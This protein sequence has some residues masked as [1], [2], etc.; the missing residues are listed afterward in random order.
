M[1]LDEF[2]EE[3]AKTPRDW[4]NTYGYV[5]RM[6]SDTR[7]CPILAVG[8]AKGLELPRTPGG[9]PS[10]DSAPTLGP[11]LGLSPLEVRQIMATADGRVCMWRER[12][13]RNRLLR[14]CGLEEEL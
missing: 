10:N 7:I 8:A 9:N 14:A 1:P 3:L 5:R 6:H 12:L 4:D 2:F 13:D 11:E